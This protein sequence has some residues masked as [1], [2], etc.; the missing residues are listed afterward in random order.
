MLTSINGRVMGLP[1]GSPTG[2]WSWAAAMLVKTAMMEALVNILLVLFGIN[3]RRA[4][5][6]VVS[7]LVGEDSRSVKSDCV[8]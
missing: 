3:V 7:V 5:I 2:A 6:K 4:T 1:A 8:L